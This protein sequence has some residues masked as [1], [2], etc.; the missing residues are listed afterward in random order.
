MPPNHGSSAKVSLTVKVKP[1]RV[2]SNPFK[3]GNQWAYKPGDPRLVGVKRSGTTK[4]RL[5]SQ[6]YRA[7]LALEDEFGITNAMKIAQQLGDA[8]LKM[9]DVGGAKEIRTATEGTQI[10]F[11][12]PASDVEELTDDEL[13]RI[14]QGEQQ[15]ALPSP[16]DVASQIAAETGEV[17]DA[18]VLAD[19]DIES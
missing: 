10:S 1:P 6:A 4:P 19:A 15:R 3:K 2:P 17:V 11:K 12:P 5:L 18:E 16:K 8:T 13:L 14:I 9:A 7:W